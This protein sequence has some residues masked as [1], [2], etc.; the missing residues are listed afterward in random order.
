MTLVPDKFSRLLPALLLLV[1][2]IGAA[3][4]AEIA[5]TRARVTEV[6]KQYCKLTVPEGHRVAVGAE[7]TLHRGAADEDALG[8]VVITAVEENYI[9]GKVTGEAPQAGDYVLIERG[10][11]PAAQEKDDEDEGPPKSRKQLLAEMRARKKTKAQKR[12]A[13][14]REKWLAR[15]EARGVEPWPELADD[16]HAAAVEE[17]KT[18]VK[19]IQRQFPAMT[20]HET[21]NFLVC[22]NIPPRQIGPYVA[23]L[24]A[25][26]EMLVKMFGIDPEHRVWRGKALV[27]AFLD[28]TQFARFEI[29][30]MK[31]QPDPQA[32]GLCHSKSDGEVIISCYRGDNPADFGHML[33]HETSHGF[34]HRYKTALRLPTWVN[35]GM[36]EWIG[37]ALVPASNSV[38]DS[39]KRAIEIMRQT[40]GMG[41]LLAAQGGIDTWQYGVA[42]SL[43]NFMIRA[44][45][46]A[47]VA[48]IEGIKEGLDWQESLQQSYHTTPAQLVAAYGQAIGVPGLRP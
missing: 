32:Y 24:D 14:E 4:A 38:R 27:V 48:F 13:V 47:Y 16:E 43:N 36:A 11:A 44:N 3:G 7:G 28:K 20:L 9:V 2:S 45:Q 30:F 23:S 12:A 34:I 33:V 6:I 8:K 37:Q 17:L 40:R 5:P 46:K 15:L 39:Q 25:M 31:H 18:L 26:H 35:E 42:S 19:E 41:G 10:E 1:L 21:E 29:R 22:T